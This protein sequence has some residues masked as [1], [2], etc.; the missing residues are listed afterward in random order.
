MRGLALALPRADWPLLAAG[1]LLTLFAYPPFHLV[2][3]SF[4]CLVPAVWLLVAAADDP[5]PLRRRMVQGFWFTLLAQGLVLY[6]M[7]VALWHFTPLSALGYGAT[8]L[9]LAL[10]GSVLFGVVG[11]VCGT[12]RISILLV[13]PVCWT[14]GEWLIGHQGDIRFPWLG[15]GTS[16]TGYPALIQIADT[17]GARGVTFL[18][19]L[20]NTILAVGFLRVADRRPA[21]RSLAVVGLGTVLALGYGRLRL[22][23]LALRPVG[24]VAVIQP[25]VGYDDKHDRS[26]YD[27]VM[28]LN[29]RLSDAALDR[30]R[31]QLVAWPE[32]AVPYFFESYPHWETWVGDQARRSGVPIL[33]GGIGLRFRPDRSYDY[34]NSAFLFEPSGRR[35]GQPPYHKR[36]L[37]PIV[38]RVPFVNPRWFSGLRWFGGFGIGEPGPVYQAPLGRFGVLICYESAFEDLTRHYRRRGADFVVNITN[39]AWFGHTSAPYQHAAHLVMRAIENRVGIARAA[40]NGISEFVDPLGRVYHA[41]RL[42]DTTFVADTVRTTDGRTIYT[43]LGDWVGLLSLIGVAVLG[44]IAFRKQKREEGEERR[45]EES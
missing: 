31:P 22:S 44:G 10:W 28:R 33:V 4:V 16:L 17:V 15:L 1:A 38:E 40:N 34:F 39:D 18:L 13:F 3:P 36:Y 11:W 14:A 6:W 30:A 45:D 19:A 27:S 21:L 29:L 23:T 26:L 25:S 43:A 37:V 42:D 8:I 7:I 35:D 20:A 5:R 32:A 24:K 12:T 2:V 41:T 9:L